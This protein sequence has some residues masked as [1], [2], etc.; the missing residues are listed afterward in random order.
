[1]NRKYPNLKEAE[2]RRSNYIALVI[3][4]SFF[5]AVAVGVYFQTMIGVIAGV[6]VAGVLI[7]KLSRLVYS[8]IKVSCPICG[9]GNLNENY[10]NT[11]RY[12]NDKVEHT[13]SDCGSFY[14]D[15]EFVESKNT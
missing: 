14:I 8:K 9:S 11:P 12:S 15:G 10:A 3:M 7:W 4:A 6:V 5:A 13:C 2:K 1:M